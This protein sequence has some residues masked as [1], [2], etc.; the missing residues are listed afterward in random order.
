MF[1]DALP[2]PLA[3]V[4]VQRLAVNIDGSL[5]MFGARSQA[6][7]MDVVHV[8]SPRP[9]FAQ[10]ST[11][12]LESKTIARAVV[13]HVRAA[14]FFGSVSLVVHPRA[15]LDAPSLV[16]D[17]R[18]LTTGRSKL[19]VDACGPATQRPQFMR[20]FHAP[21]SRVLDGLPS[22]VRK[23]PVP[24]WMAPVSGGCGGSLTAR[25]LAG[26]DLE[27]VLL[28]YLDVYLGALAGAEKL[29]HVNGTDALGDLFKAHSAAGRYLTRAFGA[30][31]K[32]RYESLVWN[33]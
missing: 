12:V 33:Q 5:R 3:R 24:E 28:R 6:A 21:L 25:P 26:R 31:F 13:S 11:C 4:N 14:P 20:R 22:S 18:I 2:G 16:V 7:P 27:R 29:E 8:A 9:P 1:L 30:G 32:E 10:M 17:F 15:V 23:R 19:Y